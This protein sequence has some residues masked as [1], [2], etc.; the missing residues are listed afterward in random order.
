MSGF[1][2]LHRA[3]LEW[4]WYQDTN[5]KVLFLHCLLKANWE[6]KSWQGIE[7]KR[8][9][10]VTSVNNLS[11]D[12]GLT[13]QQVRTA[14]NKLSK[15][16]ELTIKTTNKNTLLTIVKYDV[17]QN[18]V[19]ED[20]KQNNKQPNKQ[21][22]KLVT[23]EQQSNNNQITTTKQDNN[24][25]IEP[26]EQINNKQEEMELALDVPMSPLK[27][28]FPYDT[29]EFISQWNIW[30]KYRTESDK[31]F[32]WTIESE[33][34]ALKKLSKLSKDENEAIEIIHESMANGW[35]GLF[36]LKNENK[37]GQQKS[38]AEQF[39][40]AYNSEAARNFKFS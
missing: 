13:I 39:R 17:Y 29:I 16:N 3:I 36:A 35:K 32:K 38:T 22:N 25:T 14:I 28:I 37:N 10:F 40:D 24:L 4:E 30:K 31:K 2:T 15:T 8:G 9:S 20:N 11:F 12:L 21:N 27:I 33:Q 23:N 5:T 18:I 6:D 1:I 19:N 26:L 34:A 7:I